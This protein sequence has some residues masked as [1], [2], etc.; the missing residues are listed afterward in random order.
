QER[1]QGGQ[2]DHRVLPGRDVGDRADLHVP[3]A[4][5][6]DDQPGEQGRQERDG[7]DD[8]EQDDLDGGLEEGEDPAAGGVVYLQADDGE[9][10]GVGDPG[11]RAEQHH[12][13]DDGA[14]VR[15]QPDE[16]ERHRPGRDRDAEQPPAAE[17]AEHLGAD[18]HA[19][20]HADEDRG[21]DQTPAGAAAVQ[22][23]GDV[24]IAQA[25]HHA[26]RGE[27]AHHADHQAAYHRRL[28]DE[29]PALPDGL[30]RGRRRDL[31]AVVPL[32]DLADE[33]DGERGDEV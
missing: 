2:Q 6:A 4:V 1:H 19:Q 22:G 8:G 23:E 13:Q 32:G 33:V 17:A 27:R 21:E 3:G 16:R 29:T 11:Q 14:Q 20:R 7:G 24:E 10:G 15:D 5:Q 31:L 9:A 18:D 30:G 25:D 12:E 26:G 28:A